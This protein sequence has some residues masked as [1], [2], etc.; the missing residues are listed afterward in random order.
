MYDLLNI[1]AIIILIIFLWLLIRAFKA[2]KAAQQTDW[3]SSGMNFIDGFNRLFC[4]YYHRLQYTPIELPAQGAA[5]LVANHI[6]TLDPLLLVAATRRPL[7]FLIAREYYELFGLKW[8]FRAMGCIPVDRSVHPET[9]LRAALKALEAGEVIT[10]F[11]QGGVV[12]PGEPRK[13]KRG[14]VWLAQR[15]HST[16]YPTFVSGIA[17]T[18][19]DNI[20]IDL[21]VRS[22][23]KLESYPP[24]DW[25]EAEKN[26][27]YL[28]A[29]FEGERGEV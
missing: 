12:L 29:L 19:G 6:S 9:A 11:P 3:G 15:T 27:A 10:L 5:I 14:F 16:I 13:L 25:R 26:V 20:L 21:L 1:T 22:H 18:G 2:I 17:R 4:K 7:R 8:F 23:A 28:Q 24:L